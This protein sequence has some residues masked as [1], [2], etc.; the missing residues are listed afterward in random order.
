MAL[1]EVEDLHVSFKT[2]D[3]V[4]EAVQGVSYELDEGETLGIVGESGSG[5]SVSTMAL[6]RLIPEP[7]GKITGRV[8][9]D[10]EDVLSL[11]KSRMREIRG[12]TGLRDDQLIA[13]GESARRLG[14]RTI[15]AGDF[16]ATPWCRIFGALLETSG[17]TDA[18][19]VRFP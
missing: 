17:L 9:F 5:K 7:P 18:Y 13:I 1:L 4:V 19:M 8:R 14:A 11:P 3:G 2:D 12:N 16:N 15:V 6:M 10:G